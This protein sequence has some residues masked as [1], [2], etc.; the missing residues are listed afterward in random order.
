MGLGV[1][2]QG[3]GGQLA[4]QACTHIHTY[5]HVRAHVYTLTLELVMPP[6]GHLTP[7]PHAPTQPHE[8]ACLPACLLLPACYCLQA[9]LLRR[10]CWV[11]VTAYTPARP[12]S[13]SCYSR[14]M[15]CRCRTCGHGARRGPAGQRQGRAFKVRNGRGGGRKKAKVWGRRG[16][17]FFVPWGRG[18]GGL[19]GRGSAGAGGN[20]QGQCRGRGEHPGCIRGAAG[21]GAGIGHANV[22]R[23]ICT[24]TLR[25]AGQTRT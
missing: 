20:I 22:R 12:P 1:R 23:A 19:K 3:F 25:R 14:R 18:G 5:T 4:A 6:H 13:L 21:T 24:G 7:P 15:C 11:W 16:G 17:A 8:P 9:S 10:V 2:G